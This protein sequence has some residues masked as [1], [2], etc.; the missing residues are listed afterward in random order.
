M[1]NVNVAPSA[2][3]VLA[4]VIDPDILTVTTHDSG[5]VSLALSH[6]LLATIL[7]GIIE[8][9]GT[10]DAKLQQ[11]TDGS[12][13]GAKDIA[14]KS[15]TQM[16]VSDK[17]SLINCRGEELDVDGGFTHVELS[18]TIGT[19]NVDGAGLVHTMDG[20]YQ[21]VG[22]VSSVVETITN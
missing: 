12:G 20:R 9:G 6:N 8:S 19:A 16:L 3:A 11:A 2:R 1:S 18:I 7:V 14:G 22:Q 5:W 17:Q 4:A 15:I 10:V 21:E 13:S